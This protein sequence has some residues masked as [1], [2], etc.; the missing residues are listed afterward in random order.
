MQEEGW[1]RLCSLLLLGVQGRETTLHHPLHVRLQSVSELQ[2]WEVQAGAQWPSMLVSIPPP[3]P[4]LAAFP[5]CPLWGPHSSRLYLPEGQGYGA[6][7]GHS[8]MQP[9]QTRMVRT[10]LQRLVSTSPIIAPCPPEWAKSGSVTAFFSLG[11]MPSEA[12]NSVKLWGSRRKALASG[13][14]QSDR[15]GRALLPGRNQH[16]LLLK[17]G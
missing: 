2:L 11:F 13:S 4:S 5:L 10:S 8:W 17:W 15:E 14:S 7:L 16:P 3:H 1:E 9:A 12:E 6:G